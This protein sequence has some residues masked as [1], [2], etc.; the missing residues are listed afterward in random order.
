MST[1]EVGQFCN[2]L[3]SS[4][5]EY[6]VKKGDVVYIAGDTVVSTDEKD[7]YALRRLFIAAWMVGTSIDVNRGGFTIDGKRLKPLSDIM[8]ERLNAVKDDDF[9][10]EEVDDT[11]D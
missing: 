7:P 6:G 5:A 10:V 2:V 1:I 11:E 8:Q 4:Y 3:D 9:E